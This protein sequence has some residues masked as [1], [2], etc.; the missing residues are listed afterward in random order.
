MLSETNVAKEMMKSVVLV[1]LLPGRYQ[2][3]FTITGRWVDAE[4]IE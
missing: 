1:D 3:G 4:L 2:V